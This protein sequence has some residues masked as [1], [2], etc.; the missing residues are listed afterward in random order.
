MY[1]TG[2][3]DEGYTSLFGGERVAKDSPRI[4]ALGALDEATSAIGMARA[5]VV[6][7]ESRAILLR[8]QHEL[9][10][11]MAEIASPRP[12]RLPSRIQAEMV[13]GIETDLALLEESTPLPRTFIMPGDTPG[14]AA[15][16]F[17]RAV[18]RRAERHA[19]SLLHQGEVQNEQIIRYL[20]RASSLLYVLARADDLAIGNSHN[21]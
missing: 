2:K 7:Q 3:G 6:R 19:V 20:N 11:L 17:A 14:G 18:T 8:I 10:I 5:A 13:G 21:A 12:D 4:E 9:H 1:Y 16:D 15:L